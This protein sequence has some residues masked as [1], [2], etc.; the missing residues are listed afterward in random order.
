M[1]VVNIKK[2]LSDISLHLEGAIIHY[3][4]IA[5]GEL[6]KNA[7]RIT[8]PIEGKPSHYLAITLTG[9]EFVKLEGLS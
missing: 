9:V 2:A 8:V 5:P 4:D 3:G 1:H 6:F 7:S